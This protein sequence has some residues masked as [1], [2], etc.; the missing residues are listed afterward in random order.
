MQSCS[1]QKLYIKNLKMIGSRADMRTYIS[2]LYLSV[3]I[4][5]ISGCSSEPAGLEWSLVLHGGAGTI[6]AED[7]TPDKEIAI[8]NAMQR[9]LDKGHEILASGGTALDAVEACIRVLE[10]SPEF[11]AGKGAVFTEAGTNELDASIMDG[12]T[13]NAGAVTG[14]QHIANPISL[15]RSVMTD[16]PH[17]MMAGK[18]AEAFA[19]EQGFDTVSTSYFWTQ[20]RWDQLQN[21]QKKTE[22]KHGTVGAVALDSHGNLAAA[23]STGGM[24][25][26]RFGRIG[27]SPIIG[28][29]T[30]ANNNTCAV[31][32]TGH[33]EYFMR[34]M[35]AHSV[36]ASMEYGGLSLAT[37]AH[38][39]IEG[40]LTSLGGTGGIIA[41]DAQGRKVMEFNTTGMYRGWS[42]SAGD[43][44]ILF[45][46]K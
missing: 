8:R 44:G 35:I 13:L 23:T 2:F 6:K 5:M 21:K 34:L 37:A 31:S 20:Q 29:G 19:S 33:G 14:I 15:A 17:V 40:K 41:L 18:G 9:S 26:K 46:G 43:S 3:F 11:N 24:T 22:D 10:D 12:Q 42:D 32:A 16:S 7:M 36:S 30:Y 38:D 27:D 45:Y 4:L 28:A 25:N 39:V 1:N